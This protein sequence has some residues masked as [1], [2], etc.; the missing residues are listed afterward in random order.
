MSN[1]T[2]YIDKIKLAGKNGGEEKGVALAIAEFSVF[3]AKLAKD[4]ADTTE[5]NLRLQSRVVGLT[6]LI[7]LLTLLMHLLGFA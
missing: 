6:W 1:Y 3:L 2:E 5:K 4:P 7:L